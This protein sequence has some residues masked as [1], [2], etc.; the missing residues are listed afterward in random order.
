MSL[1]TFK[2]RFIIKANKTNRKG[3]APLFA[4]VTVNGKKIEISTQRSI[5]KVNWSSESESAIPNNQKNRAFNNYLE[6]LR[7][8]IYNGYASVL[9]TEDV[10]E[11]ETL[12]E[13]IHGKVKIKKYNLIEVAEQ[14]NEQF[15]KQVGTKYS[16]GSLKNYKTTL[17]YLKDFVPHIYSLKDIPLSKVDYKFCEAY[18]TYLTTEKTCT[19]NGACKQIQRIK[20]IV[21]Y[22]VR[23]GYISINPA[24]SFSLKLNPVNKL[25]LTMQE[26]NEIEKVV[27]QRDTLCR[28]R[29]VFIFQ[30]YTGLSYCDI[31]SLNRDNILLSDGET[32]IKMT[33]QKTQITFSVPLLS[34]ALAIL[35]K[36][37]NNLCGPILPVLSNQKMN[38]NLK[39]IQEIAGIS[40]N[41]TTHLARHSFATTIT[42]NND[43]PIETVSRMLGHTNIRTTQ[44]Y[45]KVLDVK[46]GNDMRKIKDRF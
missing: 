27:L 42:L 30:C 40:K 20:K 44:L 39:V 12:I 7:N 13:A 37:I 28:V 19:N 34:P 5:L 46:I 9:C 2:V 36:Y 25:A 32:W 18:F 41:L 11:R 26:I 17:K 3:F 21:N 23:L 14:H 29:D 8:K 15:S 45:A 6:N 4:K 43:V 35:N 22:A 33:R 10:V 1:Q 38:E 24:A 16:A 31:K